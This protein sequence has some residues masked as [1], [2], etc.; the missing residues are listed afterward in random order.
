MIVNGYWLMVITSDI[1]FTC[2]YFQHL[3]SRCQGKVLLIEY[4]MIARFSFISGKPEQYSK[5]SLK[6]KFIYR[7]LSKGVFYILCRVGITLL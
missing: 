3:L 2:N 5:C 4:C 1:L 6:M 7:Q